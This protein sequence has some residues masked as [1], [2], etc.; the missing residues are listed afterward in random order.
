[1]FRRIVRHFGP[2]WGAA[3]MGTAAI[4]IA[5][6]LSSEAARPFSF[7][8]YIG[9]GYYLLAIVM[10]LHSWYLGCFGFSGIRRMSRGT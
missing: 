10:F 1:M 7:L 5:M 6:Q 9:I 8:F 3:V 2:E 4:S